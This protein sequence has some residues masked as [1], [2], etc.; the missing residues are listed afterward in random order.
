MNTKTYNNNR[1]IT[2]VIGNELIN[3]KNNVGNYNTL[4]DSCCETVRMLR[5][6]YNA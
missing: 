6:H 2:V 5:N 1:K 3:V 4:I